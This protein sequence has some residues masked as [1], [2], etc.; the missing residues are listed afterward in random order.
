MKTLA[1]PPTFLGA[2]KNL[3]AGIY[4][5]TARFAG[6]N[7]A[8]QANTARVGSRMGTN[9]WGTM[10]Q[11]QRIGMQ[12]TA[13]MLQKNA[14]LAMAYLRVRGNYCRPQK[15]KANTGDAELNKQVTAYCDEK[16]RTM[17]VGSSM[18]AAVARTLHI[19]TPVRGDAGLIFWRDESG[20][21][22][23]IEFSADQ[24]GAIYEYTMPRTCGLTRNAKGEIVEC[25]GSDCVYLSGRYFRGADCVAYKIFERTNAFYGNPRIYDAADVIYTADPFN[26]RGLR[27]VT[28]FANVMD[29]I[30]KGEDL[31]QSALDAAQR[32]AK[33]AMAVFNNSGEPPPLAYETDVS[34]DGT[35]SY[36]ERLGNGPLTEYFYNGDAVQ[37]MSPSN[38]NNETINGIEAAD[39]RFCTGL[40]MTY[41]FVMSCKN[42][43]GAPSRLDCN[44]SGKEIERIQNDISDPCLRRIAEITIMDGV[45]RRLLPAVPNIDRGH[46]TYTNSP[47]AD[48]YRDSMDDIKSVRAGQDSDSSVISRYGRT[49]DEVISDKGEETFR[50]YM[51]LDS[52]MKRLKEAGCNLTPSIADIRQISDNPQQAA[53]A[54]QIDAGNVAQP[55]PSKPADAPAKPATAAMAEWDESKHSRDDDGEF[56]SGGGGG[57]PHAMDYEKA[58]PESAPSK[59]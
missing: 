55:V 47:T 36:R 43:G 44:R 46:W 52:V 53:A 23:L 22:R 28:I 27:G 6:Y 20:D 1:A 41:A 56:G 25:A 30:Q 57:T 29:C 13:E 59:E 37:N 10:A 5:A 19:E 38:V 31:L 40:G 4:R 49:H 8:Q 26:F 51:E 15:W 48:A 16:W 18:L 17:G 42:L 12:F 39:E 45:H 2:L 35:V 24:L 50:A 34:T 32:Q 11:M 14:P 58:H 33:T 9:S 3:G 21:L 7:A 54:E